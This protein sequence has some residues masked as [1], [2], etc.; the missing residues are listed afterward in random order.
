MSS[1]NISRFT[2][3]GSRPK[4][5][6]KKVTSSKISFLDANDEVNEENSAKAVEDKVDRVDFFNDVA[7]TVPSSEE[8]QEGSAF[9][10]GQ[11][12]S[13]NEL[14]LA[15]SNTKYDIF[16]EFL[17]LGISKS[18]NKTKDEVKIKKRRGV[19]V[20]ATNENN[21]NAKKRGVEN[22]D[23]VRKEITRRALKDKSNKKNDG[24]NK[25]NEVVVRSALISEKNR[26]KDVLR[27]DFKIHE[28]NSELIV[29]P[30]VEPG[31]DWRDMKPI[32]TS[33]PVKTDEDSQPHTNNASSAS[34]EEIGNILPSDDDAEDSQKQVEQPTRS[35]ESEGDLSPDPLTLPM[36]PEDRRLPPPPK[37][38]Y[39]IIKRIL[40][41]PLTPTSEVDEL[42]AAYNM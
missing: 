34:L 36:R 2:S 8:K 40:D 23:V 9:I 35:H 31:E 7:N 38:G 21:N 11:I 25:T 6:F 33:T 5:T 30:A 16:D 15:Q 17:E 12:I 20:D 4:Y 24:T 14:A 1:F 18:V 13:Q 41:K 27:V 32:M 22:D 42:S 28:D 29:N 10:L 26:D 39:Q 3:M 37:G 19:N